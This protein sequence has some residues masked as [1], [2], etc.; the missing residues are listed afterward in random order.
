MPI[1]TGFPGFR[2]NVKQAAPRRARHLLRQKASEF[3]QKTHG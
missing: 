3:S 1:S 2:A